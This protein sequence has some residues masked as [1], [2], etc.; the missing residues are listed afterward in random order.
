MFDQE[1]VF[2]SQKRQPIAWLVPPVFGLAPEAAS[3]GSRPCNAA[4]APS[5]LFIRT[6]QRQ[7][8]P[9]PALSRSTSGKAQAFSGAAGGP[10][11]P[12]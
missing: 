1:A 2:M 10:C 8:L 3:W 4:G 5:H 12:S 6:F 11:E 7:G 9:H